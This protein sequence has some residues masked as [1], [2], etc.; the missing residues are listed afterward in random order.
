MSVQFARVASHPLG[1]ARPH[2]QHDEGAS[3][4]VDSPALEVM[5]DLRRVQVVTVEPEERADL[6]LRQMA[7]AGVRL[8][9][10]TS[11]NDEV[12]GVLSARDVLG[13]RPVQVASRERIHRDEVTVQQIMTPQEQIDAL[14]LSDVKRAQVGDIVETLRAAGRQHALVMDQTSTGEVVCGIFSVTHIG[15]QLGVEISSEGRVQSFAELALSD[16]RPLSATTRG[17]A[18]SGAPRVEALE[19]FVNRTLI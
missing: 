6:A 9:L 2:R 3:V 8:L 11:P 19:A 15:R 12:V 18:G 17:A 7:H 4:T 1:A 14:N 10:V 5:T 13:E 16:R